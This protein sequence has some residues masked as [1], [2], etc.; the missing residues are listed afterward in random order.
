MQIVMGWRELVSEG[1][2]GPVGLARQF[3]K[4]T[5]C[6]KYSSQLP[7]TIRSTFESLNNLRVIY[8]YRNEVNEI[9]NRNKHVRA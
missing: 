3:K 7:K 4:Q 1:T 5:S 8:V 9:L 2:L 6:E